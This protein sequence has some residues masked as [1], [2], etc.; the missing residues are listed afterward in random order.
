[1]VERMRAEFD[2]RFRHL[3]NLLRQEMRACIF[4]FALCL[5]GNLSD[6]R[7]DEKDGR[8][9]A[10]LPQDGESVLIIIPPPIIKRDGERAR[11]ECSVLAKM[12]HQLRSGTKDKS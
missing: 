11:R 6:T 5:A 2:S 10:V 1:M 9:D 12:V 7:S 4:S 3:Q 8:R